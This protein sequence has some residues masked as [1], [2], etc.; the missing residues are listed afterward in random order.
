MSRRIDAYNLANVLGQARLKHTASC[1]PVACPE[2]SNQQCG[3]FNACHPVVGRL[4]P[5]FCAGRR[6]AS[7]AR[8]Q[9]PSSSS[10]GDGGQGL[11][12]LQVA[13]CE[14]PTAGQSSQKL[15]ETAGGGSR[16]PGLSCPAVALQ[17]LALASAM[18]SAVRFP[19]ETDLPMYAQGDR[20][21]PGSSI[22]KSHSA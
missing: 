10:P 22:S 18:G 6:V 19:P 1:A 13:L 11:G 14:D 8:G 15:T 12:A 4:L 16:C 17:T 21:Q 9:P 20:H 5:A 7:E 3:V 2:G